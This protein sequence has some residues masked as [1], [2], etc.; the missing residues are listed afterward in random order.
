MSQGPQSPG[1]GANVGA[2]SMVRLSDDRVF[3]PADD[4]LLSRWAA[5]GRIP[6]DAMLEPT[7]GGAAVRA[8]EH[9]AIRAVLDAPPTVAGPLASPPVTDGPMSTLIPY[10]NG[11]ALAAYYTGVFSLIPVLALPLGPAAIVL[12]V[13]GLKYARKHPLARGRVHAWVGL[14]LGALTLLANAAVIV[15]ALLMAAR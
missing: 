6:R 1:A 3:G 4:A 2:T 13:L 10:R 14:V 5:E 12:G 11:A 7:D 15:F 8:T 9:P